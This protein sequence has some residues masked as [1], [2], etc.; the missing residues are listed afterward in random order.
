[1][2]VADQWIQKDGSFLSVGGLLIAMQLNTCMFLNAVLDPLVKSKQG[3]VY[4]IDETVPIKSVA[5]LIDES[6]VPEKY[7]AVLKEELRAVDYDHQGDLDHMKFFDFANKAM[8]WLERW[9]SNPEPN[10]TSNKDL[11]DLINSLQ[12]S[13]LV[14]HTGTELLE[15]EKQHGVTKTD[16]DVIEDTESDCEGVIDTMLLSIK[17]LATGQPLSAIAMV[18]FLLVMAFTQYGFNCS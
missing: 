6:R 18:F 8:M 11:N 13:R 4:R 1:M 3:A 14:E 9:S 16:E 2:T 10:S 15:A 7:K 5:H 12:F 17:H